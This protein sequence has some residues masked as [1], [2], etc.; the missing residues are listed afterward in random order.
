MKTYVFIML[1]WGIGGIVGMVNMYLKS[2]NENTLKKLY[3]TNELYRKWVDKNSSYTEEYLSGSA[4]N[5]SG[6]SLKKFENELLLFSYPDRFYPQKI[7]NAPHMVLK[8]KSDNA[9]LTIGQWDYNLASSVDVWDVAE[10]CKKNVMP[11]TQ[12]VDVKKMILETSDGGIHCVKLITNAAFGGNITGYLV[13]YIVHKGCLINFGY[14]M[15]H[16]VDKS[17][18]TDDIDKLFVGLKLK[19]GNDNRLGN[20]FY[21]GDFKDKIIELCKNINSQCPIKTN[22][23]MELVCMYYSNNMITCKYIVDNDIAEYIDNDWAKELKKGT[24]DNFR[25]LFSQLNW[26][27]E[28][29]YKCISKENTSILFYIFNKEAHLLKTIKIIPDDFAVRTKLPFYEK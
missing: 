27:P 17:A 16:I 10:Y 21:V 19:G 12:L 26:S 23:I 3:A 20:V 14:M 18:S 8:L 13:Y 4:D 24:I 2:E 22:D 9:L 6:R 5:V 25:E 11:G 15:D 7:N 1:F 28:T 29:L